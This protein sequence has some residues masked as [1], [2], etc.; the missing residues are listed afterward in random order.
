MAAVWIVSALVWCLYSGVQGD[1]SVTTTVN[2]VGLLG[3][4]EVELVCTYRLASVDTVF[5][6]SWKRETSKDS[7][8]YEQ[9]AGFSPPRASQRPATLNNLT[10]PSVTGR[11]VLTNPTY[12]SLTAKM[13][14]ISVV[15]GDE[16]KYQCTV[17]GLNN[18]AQANPTPASVN[19][20]IV[21]AKPNART[22]HE[23]ELVPS[24]NVEEGQ[25]VTFTC[26]GNVGRPAGNFLWTRLSSTIDGTGTPIDSTTQT[27]PS[28]DCTY[29]GSSVI[30][31]QMTKDDNGI[32]VKCALQQETISDPRDT[33]Y[34]KLTNVINVF[35]KVRAPTI[36]KSPN[37]AVH[38]E[39]TTLTLTCAAEGNP[40]PTYVWRVN[41]TQVGTSAQLQLTNIKI[42][43]SGDYVCEATNNFNGNTYNMSSTVDITIE[44]PPSTIPT[45]TETDDRDSTRLYTAGVVMLCVLV[46]L[47]IVTVVLGIFIGRNKGLPCFKISKMEESTHF[48]RVHHSVSTIQDEDERSRYQ[49]LDSADIAGPSVYQALGQP[50]NGEQGRLDRN[51]DMIKDKPAPSLYDEVHGPGDGYTRSY[52]NMAFSGNT[53]TVGK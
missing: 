14:F 24:S 13:K 29:T 28:A 45:T 3:D 51:D 1:I 50:P 49:Q 6:M 48:Q 12:S 18:D 19:S 32:V 21:V 53:P 8:T 10:N 36:T 34:F 17:L 40:T 2:P 23:V 16:R 39:D 46:I 25:T 35:Y 7:G 9:I 27:S 20:L 37:K 33:A 44:T 22:F 15:C 47:L 41:G 26:T 11:V 42:A 30:S 31:I 43:Q 4:N 5:S 52:V 38:Y